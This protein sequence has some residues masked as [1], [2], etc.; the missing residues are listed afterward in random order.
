MLKIKSGELKLH[1]DLISCFKQDKLTNPDR[2][3]EK[4]HTSDIIQ[5]KEIE[6]D[7]K[8]RKGKKR[9]MTNGAK[10]IMG[11]NGLRKMKII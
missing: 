7:L 11:R 9:P 6:C 1:R 10:E 5:R 8:F 4:G 2:F 3:I